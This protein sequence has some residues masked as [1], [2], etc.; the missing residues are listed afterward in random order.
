LTF[1]SVAAKDLPGPALGLRSLPGWFDSTAEVELGRSFA[2]S[3]E[4][5]P[6]DGGF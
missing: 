6:W 4:G 5:A 2:S 3:D 1:A